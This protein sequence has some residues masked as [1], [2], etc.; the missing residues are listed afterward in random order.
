MADIYS[1]LMNLDMFA[2]GAVGIVVALVYATVRA[3]RTDRRRQ[4]FRTDAGKEETETTKSEKNTAGT[5][6]FLL[7]TSVIRGCSGARLTQRAKRG[8]LC[9]SATTAWELLC[10][11]NEPNKF[12][13]F[14][15]QLLKLSGRIIPA[16]RRPTARR[17]RRSTSCCTQTGWT[18]RSSGPWR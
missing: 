14:K 4:G 6:V 7:D 18:K 9:V 5:V 3:A 16:L 10:H 2:W 13:F 12:E 17:P 8:D 11:L 1:T 15:S